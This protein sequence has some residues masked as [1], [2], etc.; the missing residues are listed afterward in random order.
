MF[1]E[2]L[3]FQELLR[4]KMRAA[5]RRFAVIM[6]QVRLFLTNEKHQMMPTF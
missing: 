6:S 1:L 3:R 2:Q 5:A 4:V